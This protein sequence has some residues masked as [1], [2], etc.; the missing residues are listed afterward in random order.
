[1]QVRQ[2]YVEQIMR[3]TESTSTIAGPWK[4]A[5]Y[6]CLLFLMSCGS[7]SAPS[8]D[9][10]RDDQSPVIEDENL[11]F[12]S[13]VHYLHGYIRSDQVGIRL[14]PIDETF[15]L[16]FTEA[17]FSASAGVLR[18]S[19]P[20]FDM[21]INTSRNGNELELSDSRN[22]RPLGCQSTFVNQTL[23]DTLQTVVSV[24]QS[25]V[26]TIE[27]TEN[28]LLLGPQGG[29]L[30]AFSTVPLRVDNRELNEATSISQR[31]WALES[32][33]TLESG[34]AAVPLGMTA[35][36]SFGQDQTLDLDLGCSSGS[37]GVRIGSGIISIIDLS[38]TDS[39]CLPD[40]LALEDLTQD[41]PTELVEAFFTRGNVIPLAFSI[42][43]DQ[44]MLFNGRDTV[45]VFS[46]RVINES[47]SLP[48]T[49]E[50]DRGDL[51]LGGIDVDA[52]QRRTDI[53]RDQ[54]ALDELYGSLLTDFGL[55]QFEAPVVDF[56]RFTVIA[57]F[58]GHNNQTGYDLV[59]RSAVETE[60]G[61]DVFLTSR[62]PDDS[63]LNT[64]CFVEE[65]ES[66]PFSIV[67]V[68]SR[69][70]PVTTRIRETSFCTGLWD[71]VG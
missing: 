68:D 54:V 40:E 52:V 66:A 6:L 23:T 5:A 30:L 37:G 22:T 7:G 26:I 31:R 34:F 2:D 10:P 39:L 38:F 15:E 11:I 19:G 8:L 36:M 16:Q 47:E 17:T 41:Y 49:S 60:S 4:K 12:S 65:A 61:L 67:L 3:H 32:I 13:P 18:V 42:V 58:Y 9:E 1:M 56:T 71:I 24:V 53:I 48:T 63:L 43:N 69:Q 35:F 62:D 59:V 50:L 14:L 29:E 55:T 70:T 27:S 51:T 46:G 33:R 25:D 57:A 45:L 28:Y 64:N 20:C 44:L 21:L